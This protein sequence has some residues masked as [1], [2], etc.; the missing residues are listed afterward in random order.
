MASISRVLFLEG[1][2]KQDLSDTSTK[3]PKEDQGR[4][5]DIKKA[6]GVGN[7]TV[8]SVLDNNTTD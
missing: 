8:P 6:C 3:D 1:P 4:T 2:A 7:S 5:S